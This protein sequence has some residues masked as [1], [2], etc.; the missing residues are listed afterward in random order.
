MV[1]SACRFTTVAEGVLDFVRACQRPLA[2]PYDFVYTSGAGQPLVYCSAYAAMARDLAGSLGSE[3]QAFRRGWVDYLNAFQCE[4]GLYR[5]PAFGLPDDLSGVAFAPHAGWDGGIAGWGWWHMTNHVLCALD[6]LGGVAAR[7]IR[8]LEDFYSGRIVLEEW[9]ERRDW[10]VAWAVG[11]EVLNL[12]SFLL[13]ARDF[14]NES[15]AAD[16]VVRLF[17][18][19]DARQDPATGYWGNDCRS[20]AGK[21]HAMC[22]AY[23]E[24]ILYVY[25]ERPIPHLS[26]AVDATLS[27]QDPASGGFALDGSSGA[28]EDIDAA[29]ILAN[30]YLLQDYRRDDIER[31]LA[32][33]LGTILQHQNPDGGL[34]YRRGKPYVY[35]HPLMSSGVDESAL[36]PSWFRLLS[37]ALINQLIPHPKADPTPWKFNRAPY[38]HYFPSGRLEA[39]RAGKP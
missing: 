12:G 9:L 22:G 25:D 33:V 32:R 13:Y 23:H 11:N 35:G 6:S 16:L 29:F 14:H 10:D 30:A 17:D 24:Y 2:S 15:R 38:L 27:L 34:V 4:D 28:C 20:R 5:D 39:V 7:P 19:L 36:F 3:S 8:L 21:L 1:E 18:W 31:A 37:I 26:A